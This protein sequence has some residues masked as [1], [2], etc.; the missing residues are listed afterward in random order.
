[1]DIWD[2][3]PPLRPGAV[4]FDPTL[5]RLLESWLAGRVPVFHEEMADSDGV[6]RSYSIYEL[7]SES[8]QTARQAQSITR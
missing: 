2:I 5:G 8:E 4:E 1:M 6:V 3:C 7:S